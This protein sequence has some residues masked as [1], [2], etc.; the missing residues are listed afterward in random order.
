MLIQR[1]LQDYGQIKCSDKKKNDLSDS[2]VTKLKNSEIW[3]TKTEVLEQNHKR[4]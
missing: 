4:T 2:S 3:K 1:V